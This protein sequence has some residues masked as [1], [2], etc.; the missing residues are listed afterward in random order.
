[1]NSLEPMSPWIK[2]MGDATDE[3]AQSYLGFDSGCQVRDALPGMPDRFKGAFVTLLSADLSTQIGIGSNPGGCQ[4]L[5]QAMIGEEDE[6]L[7]D[8][9]VADVMGEIA[10]IVA[11]GVK[12]RL[13][14]TVGDLQLGLPFVIDGKIEAAGKAM[15]TAVDVTIGPVTAY[16]L[17]LQGPRPDREL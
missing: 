13:A 2:A 12:K 14:D 10:N 16:F 4:S 11:G 6:E 1:M 15:E 7:P 5:A 3:L 8:E 17:I 9:D